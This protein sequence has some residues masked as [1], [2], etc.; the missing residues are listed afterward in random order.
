MK[1]EKANEILKAVAEHIDPKVAE[2]IQI[3]MKIYELEDAGADMAKV[4]DHVEKKTAPKRK[5]NYKEKKCTKCGKMFIPRYGAQKRCDP[6]MNK[7]EI[8][9]TARE[10]LD[11]EG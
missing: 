5:P 11:M 7:K 3:A 8:E 9:S 6:C 4:K 2:G 1:N 10:L